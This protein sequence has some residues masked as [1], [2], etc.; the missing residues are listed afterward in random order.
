MEDT[1]KDIFQSISSFFQL[2]WVKALVA[3]I[4]FFLIFLAGFNFGRE[5]GR[6][7]MPNGF[8][9]QKMGNEQRPS[10]MDGNNQ[11]GISEETGV[12]PVKQNNENKP[13]ASQVQQNSAVNNQQPATSTSTAK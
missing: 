5:C 12:Q 10:K 4:I 3:F 1:K 8:I 13:A 7:G 2:P 11:N 9:G 6:Q